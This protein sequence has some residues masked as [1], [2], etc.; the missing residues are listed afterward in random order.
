MRRT[1]LALF[2]GAAVG[3]SVCDLMHVRRGVLSHRVGGGPAGQAWWVA[4]MFGA[5]GIVIG[6]AARPFTRKEHT[7]IARNAVPFVTAYAATAYLSLG[8]PRALTAALWATGLARTRDDLPFTLL[9]AASGPAVE[10]AI[11]RTGAFT[12]TRPEREVLPWLT[13]LY[14]HGAPLALAVANA[15]RT[16]T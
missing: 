4:P 13:G 1:N 8:H 14:I 10:I 9:L 6:H 11:S 7:A 5:A 16:R 12:Y 3:L 2:A 15:A